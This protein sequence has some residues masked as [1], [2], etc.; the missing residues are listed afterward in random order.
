[1]GA[2]VLLAFVFLGVKYV[3]YSQK[4]HAGHV[5]STNNFYA[6]YFALTG[7]H[8]LHIVAGILVNACTFDLWQRPMEDESGDV[9]QPGRER[10]PILALC[11]PGL[12]L[13]L[14]RAVPHLAHGAFLYE[15][16]E[17]SE[18]TL[19]AA[20]TRTLL[21]QREKNARRFL[22][23]RA[24]GTSVWFAAAV[25]NPA[26]GLGR[27]AGIPEC[28]AIGLVALASLGVMLAARR[29]KRVLDAAWFS[30]AIIDMPAVFLAQSL[31]IAHLDALAARSN[32]VFT[33]G[34]YAMVTAISTSLSA[35]ATSSPRPAK[36]ATVLQIVLLARSGQRGGR[37]ALRCVGVG[38]YRYRLLD[39]HRSEHRPDP[40]HG[41]RGAAQREAWTLLFSRGERADPQAEPQQPGRAPR[42]SCLQTSN[43]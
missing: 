38:N 17:R 41:A 29:W 33:V 26:T 4:I 27:A 12:D 13:P 32:G 14:S 22:M 5:P 42:P 23:L 19:A 6:I 21:L 1:M 24:I 3:E 40:Q 28:A 35:R 39:S 15:E 37:L 10:R 11:R 36:S 9:H 31:A 8:G 2:T 16:E 7:L 43:T 34:I 20:L 30:L 25:L 18:R